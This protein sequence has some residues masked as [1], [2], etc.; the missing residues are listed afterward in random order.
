VLAR[1]GRVSETLSRYHLGRRIEASSSMS[2]RPSAASAGVDDGVDVIP[3]AR[4]QRLKAGLIDVVIV[5]VLILAL[6]LVVVG[7]LKA[8]P[9]PQNLLLGLP[10][11][12]YFVLLELRPGSHRGQTLGKQVV[13]LRVV[14]STGKPASVRELVLREGFRIAIGGPAFLVSALSPLTA[15]DLG[16]ILVNRE[17]RAV[18]DLIGR[19]YVVDESSP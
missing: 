7:H 9:S 13:K 16:W 2:S 6:H 10:E 11:L 15:A 5:A 3:A 1:I 12:V 14:S 4:Q 17:N 18:H 8:S 19:T